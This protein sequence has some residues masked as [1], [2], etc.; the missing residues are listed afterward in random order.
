MGH[1]LTP[2]NGTPLPSQEIARRLRDRFAYVK[3]DEQEGLRLAHSMAARLERTPKRAFLGQH[4]EALAH[5]KRLREA[6]LGEVL[7]IEFG[8]DPSLLISI[9]VDP[10]EPIRISYE[11]QDD[12]RDKRSL[13]EECARALDCDV[14]VF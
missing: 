5:A 2:R 12:E 1:E 4:D 13:T 3:V 9:V 10:S 11:N 7:Y 14:E 6:P 8:D